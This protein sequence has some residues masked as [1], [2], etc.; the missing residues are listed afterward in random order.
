MSELPNHAQTASELAEPAPP[1]PP[2][3]LSARARRRAWIEPR[4][5]FWWMLA[6][7]LLAIGIYLLIWEYLAWRQ[8]SRLIASGTQVPATVQSVGGI[9]FAGKK[10]KGEDGPIQLRYEWQGQTYDVTVASIPGMWVEVGKPIPLR[11]D[12]AHPELWTA[13]TAPEPLMHQ[14]I[15]A[16]VALPIGLLVLAISFALWARAMRTW[17]DGQAQ[18]ALVIAARHTALAPRSWQ[19]QC[20]LAD[21][22]DKR[23]LTVFAPPQALPKEGATIWLLALPAGRPVAANWFK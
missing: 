16:L 5:R 12:P 1:A 21:Q 23:L 15:G 7:A 2:R 11:I 22:S 14:L 19:V 6:I 4:I 17:R 9:T 3:P 13:R 10:Y 20:T 8:D 18:A